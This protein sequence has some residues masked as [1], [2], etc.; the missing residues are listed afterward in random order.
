MSFCFLSLTASNFKFIETVSLLCFMSIGSTWSLKLATLVALSTLIFPDVSS[1]Y[2]SW[3]QLITRL[4]LDGIFKWT[5]WTTIW[6]VIPYSCWPLESYSISSKSFL[7]CT[8]DYFWL[9][10][11]VWHWVEQASLDWWLN[12][13]LKRLLLC[14]FKV[15]EWSCELSFFLK[16]AKDLSTTLSD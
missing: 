10:L 7:L 5:S 14:Y 1:F 9:P 15:V 11:S 4:I 2:S 3:E 13:I 12:C 6:T 8:F 16:L